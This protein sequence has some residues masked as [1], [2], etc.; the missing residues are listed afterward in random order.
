MKTRRLVA[1]FTLVLILSSTFGFVNAQDGLTIGAQVEA[2]TVGVEETAYEPGD[3]VEISGNAGSLANVSIMVFDGYTYILDLNVTAEEDGEYVVEFD[4]PEDAENGTYTVTVLTDG[5]SLQTH[6]YVMVQDLEELA[7]NLISQ[8]EDGQENIEDI[9]EEL[10]E[11]GID[12]P[13][14]A[15]ESYNLG[16]AVLEA[17]L[18]HF[19]DGNYTEAGDYAFSAVPLFGAAFEQVQ[20]LVLVETSDVDDGDEDEDEDAEGE[21][22]GLNGISIALE[23][24][25]AYWRKLNETVTRF[26]EDGNDISE[27]REVL[28]DA[29]IVLDESGEH[30]VEGNFT[31]AR[32]DFTRVRSVLGRINGLLKRTIKAHKENQAEQ[33][34]EQF[35]RRIQNMNGTIARIQDKLD[36]V[37]AQNFQNT[38]NRTAEKLQRLR[39]RLSED[40]LEDILDE[41]DDAVEEVEDDLDELDGRG[42]SAQIKNLNKVEAK[43]RALN[44]TAERLRERGW[45]TTDTDQELEDADD[46]WEELKEM[47]EEG[48][49][50][51]VKEFLEDMEDRFEDLKDELKERLKENRRITTAQRKAEEAI[52]SIQRRFQERKHNFDELREEI[53]SL[54]EKATAL[55]GRGMNVSD[56]QAY[57]SLAREKLGEA[58]EQTDLASDASQDLAREVEILIDKVEDLI[59]DFLETLGET[60]SFETGETGRNRLGIVGDDDDDE[61]DDEE[62]P[63]EG[64]N[65]TTAVTTG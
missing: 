11:D 48:E 28:D 49:T 33:F 19:E 39:G 32:E 2:M 25:Y 15:N 24:A 31:A 57:L 36:G 8:A 14:G 43:I 38:L 7:E 64:T 9:F 21:P 47:L 26:G 3:S 42:F 51:S 50:E 5:E 41:L 35:Q 40:D 61:P 17:A 60:G 59:E 46:L 58:L 29:K 27:I 45:N 62:P 37:N 63:E 56:I 18:A 65:S 34:M 13:P 6:F 10:E 16:V 23:R 52:S 54:T 12:I 1:L 4:L 55:S 22:Q 44:R 30:V 20:D 53:A